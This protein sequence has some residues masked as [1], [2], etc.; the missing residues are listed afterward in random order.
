MEKINNTYCLLTVGKVSQSTEAAPRK[1]Y[2][3]VG[4]SFVLAVNPNKKKLEEIY[5]HEIANEPVYVQENAES[6]TIRID[7]IVKT[8]PAQCNGVEMINTASFFL[9]KEAVYNSDKTKIQVID[10]YGN[11]AWPLVEDQQM[12]KIVLNKDGKNAKIA[13][14]Y[15][16]AYRGEADL[17]DFLR[18]Y[19]GVPDVFDYVNGEWVMKTENLDDYKIGLEHIKDYFS[20]NVSEL[21]EALKLMPNNKLKLLYGVRTT[22]RGQFQAVNTRSGFFLRNSSNNLNGIQRQLDGATAGNTEYKACWLAEYTPNTT[23]LSSS[24]SAPADNAMPWD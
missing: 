23:D 20:G 18:L 16:P 1:L 19:L 24:A 13:P 2:Q 7:F 14:K 8:D 17:I 5:G 15:R 12:G 3:G 10:E 22:D 11:S 21:E 6:P 4:S 9:S